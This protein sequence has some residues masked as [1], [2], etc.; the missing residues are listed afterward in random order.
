MQV[1]AD[2]LVAGEQAVVRVGAGGL[3]VVVAGADVAIAAQHAFLAAHHHDQLGV[4][5]VADHSVHDVRTGLLQ[6]IRE[7]DVRSLVEARHQLDDDGHVLA[8][9][10]RL[11]QRLDDGGIRT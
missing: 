4:R 7:L 8:V 9:A 6:A 2:G 3:R 10:R 5:L 1:L 11:D